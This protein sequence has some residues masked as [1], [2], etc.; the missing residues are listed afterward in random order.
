[1]TGRKDSK[2][3]VSRNFNMKAVSIRTQ[4]SPHVIRVW[5]RRY[6][7]VTPGRTETQRRL[8][9]EEDVQRLILLRKATEAGHR[10]GQISNLSREELLKLI[11]PSQFFLEQEQSV[12]PSGSMELISVDRLIEAVKEY[13]E[14]TLHEGLS[15]AAV[16]LSRPHLLDKIIVPLMIK[17]GDQWHEGALR[18]AH[19]HFAT[20]I[21]RTFLG[22]LNDGVN[23]PENAPSLVVTTP[24][25]QVHEMGAL[26]VAASALSLGWQALYLGP[27]LPAEEI[28]AAMDRNRSRA[29]ALSIVYP[30]GDMHVM[31]ELKKLRRLLSSDKSII[32]GGRS[33]GSY[34]KVL[35]EIQAIV[36]PDAKSLGSCLDDLSLA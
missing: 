26:V 22:H 1:M 28:C 9:S 33:A 34:R 12:S 36:L 15:R 27:N 10:I 30:P 21:V 35:E 13:D 19:E 11:P 14:A 18:V 29:V 5:E 4:L 25:G 23:L 7:A 32:V 31:E 17:V 24:P 16:A 6:Q 8:Y 2:K 3:S 20:A